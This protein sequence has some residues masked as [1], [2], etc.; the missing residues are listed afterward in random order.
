[1]D[2]LESDGFLT[3]INKRFIIYPHK[4]KEGWRQKAYI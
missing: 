3:S 1:M 4:G 2:D